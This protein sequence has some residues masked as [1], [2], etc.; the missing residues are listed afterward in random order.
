MLIV[1][2]GL[3]G[4]GTSTIAKK[5]SEYDEGSYLL[6][7]PSLEYTDRDNI[8][9]IVRKES[10][11]GHMLYYLSSTVYI[12]DY[13][14]NNIDYKK[15]NVYVVRYLIDTVVSNRVAGINI[16]LNYNIYGHE[17]LKPDL[18]IFVNINEILRSERIT[19]RGKS[20]LDKVLDNTE[21]RIAF[22]KEFKILLK[23]EKVISINND[24]IDVDNTVDGLYKKI[25]KYKQFL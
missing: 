24:S 14:K 18:T 20:E 15:N 17:I 7:T 23:N 10:K 4:S 1:I 19:N 16:D 25:L 6:K 12:S 2:T 21:K 3:D 13:I 5:L 8:D 11:V 22:L 9:K